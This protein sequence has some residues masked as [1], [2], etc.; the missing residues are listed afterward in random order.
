MVHKL[1]RRGGLL[2]GASC[3][4][5]L[6]GCS[7]L[8]EPRAEKTLLIQSNEQHTIEQDSQGSYQAVEI[9][10]S[11]VLQVNTNAEIQ[12]DSTSE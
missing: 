10:N 8:E 11:G 9:H 1:T 6:A 2:L 7:S 12:L 4:A 5:A 3:A